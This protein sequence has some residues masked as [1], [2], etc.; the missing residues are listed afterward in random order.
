MA[1]KYDF[2]GNTFWQHPLVE[3]RPRWEERLIET[4]EDWR[5]GP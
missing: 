2:L 5:V 1:S 3:R 4:T